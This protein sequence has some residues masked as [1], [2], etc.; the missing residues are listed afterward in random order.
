MLYIEQ[1]PFKANIVK[2]WKC[3]FVALIITSLKKRF[4]KSQEIKERNATI[5]KAYE[6][7]YLQHRIAK[8]SVLAQSNGKWDHQERDAVMRL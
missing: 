8:V 3:I 5:C 1:N 4:K 7:V 6:E 2:S